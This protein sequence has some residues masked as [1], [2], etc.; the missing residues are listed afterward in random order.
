MM[1]IR[2][3]RDVIVPSVPPRHYISASSPGF[4][5]ELRTAVISGCDR[6]PR[7]GGGRYEAAREVYFFHS[8]LAAYAAALSLVDRNPLLALFRSAKPAL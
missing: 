7:L 3:P 1:Q 4:P 8:P 6:R 5:A 2:A